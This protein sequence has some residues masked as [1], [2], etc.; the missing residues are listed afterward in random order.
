M[1]VGSF[2]LT[3][4]V[5]YLAHVR[6]ESLS[7]RHVTTDLRA[8]AEAIRAYIRTD[9]LTDVYRHSVRAVL[10]GVERLHAMRSMLDS[11]A[12]R[13]FIDAVGS[14]V[15]QLHWIS[16]VTSSV[17]EDKLPKGWM[18]IQ[19]EDHYRLLLRVRGSR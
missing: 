2:L 18:R 6:P 3:R 4:H 19:V 1:A 9:G 8:F 5:G 15:T 17:L 10:K 14:L 12:E 13:G 11:K 16:T 7:S